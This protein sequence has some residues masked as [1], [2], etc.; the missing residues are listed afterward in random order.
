MRE[1]DLPTRD[2]AWAED[3][4]EKILQTELQ[5]RRPDGQDDVRERR[6]AGC[7][8]PVTMRTQRPDAR[9]TYGNFRRFI[10]QLDEAVKA[11]FQ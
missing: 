3:Q 10:V 7:D 1:L 8:G 11:G 9:A 2:A 6:A 5:M 4:T